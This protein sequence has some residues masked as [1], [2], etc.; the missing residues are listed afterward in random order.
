MKYMTQHKFKV[1]FVRRVTAGTGEI[2][3]KINQIEEKGSLSLE[4]V[5]L[6]FSSRYREMRLCPAGNT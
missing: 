1:L 5:N 4:M 6:C 2:P 3:P